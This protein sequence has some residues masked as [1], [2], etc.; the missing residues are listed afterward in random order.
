MTEDLAP[1]D[2]KS[3]TEVTESQVPAS[4]TPAE[5][6][7]PQADTKASE[8]ET[9]T[10]KGEAEPE[11]R[12]NARIRQ[13]VDEKKAANAAADAAK[14][15]EAEARAQADALKRQLDAL[16][17]QPAGN[18]LDHPNQASYVTAV[19][20]EAAIE[21]QRYALQ[22]QQHQAEQLAAESKERAY[23]ARVS[24]FMEKAPDYHSVTGNPNLQ[25]TPLMADAI[26]ETESGAAIAY[27][28][29]KNPAEAARIASLSPIGQAAAIG[30]LEA[31]VTLP[32]RRTSSAPAPVK[33][34]SGAAGVTQPDPGE[35]SFED[36]RKWRQSQ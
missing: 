32:E 25:I 4:P 26:K 7:T 1:T 29:G 10:G 8:P 34:I 27:Y 2:V 12:A 11:S 19:A 23:T 17:P 30:R 33:T 9:S 16:K 36:F 20:K 35:M 21:A 6:A 3:E 22:H 14:A 28:L 18:E 24:E 15:R 13:L 5:A 31:K